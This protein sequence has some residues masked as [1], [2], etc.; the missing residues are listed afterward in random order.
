MGTTS[1]I[2][3]AY[4]ELVS[5][6]RQT[7]MLKSCASVLGWDEQ[8]YLPPKAA[9]TARISLAVSRDD[10]RTGHRAPDGRTVFALGRRQ[11]L[12]GRRIS[13]SSRCA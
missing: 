13:A 4:N 1:E 12:R 6:L 5:S 8:T 10:A 3:T 2:N 9:S 7:A 11:R